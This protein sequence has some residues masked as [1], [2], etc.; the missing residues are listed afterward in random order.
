MGHSDDLWGIRESGDLRHQFAGGAI[1]YVESD[2]HGRRTMVPYGFS[3]P[4]AAE[5][6]DRGANGGK[7][8]S[9]SVMDLTVRL[10]Q[11]DL[12]HDIQLSLLS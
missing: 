8:F 3:C 5:M 12:D 11:Q 2:D 9:K 7:Q 6:R 10:D 4:G 1:G